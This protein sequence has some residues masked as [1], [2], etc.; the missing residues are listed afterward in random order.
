MQSLLRSRLV[1]AGFPAGI[2]FVYGEPIGS[3]IAHGEAKKD[4]G[5]NGRD[6]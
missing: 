4:G 2:F 6:K 1:L 3:S 5:V